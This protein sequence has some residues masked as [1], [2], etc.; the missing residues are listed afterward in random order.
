MPGPQQQGMGLG[1]LV[2]GSSLLLLGCR[3]LAG[4]GWCKG[5]AFVTSSIGVI[6]ALIALFVFFPIAMILASA[7]AD[8]AGQPMPAAF[9][10][11]M[12]DASIWGLGCLGGGVACG[13]AWNTVLLALV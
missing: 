6:V 11:R 9:A 1:A 3:G 8:Q 4:L 12:G 7:F 5:D 2:V 13:V 10:E